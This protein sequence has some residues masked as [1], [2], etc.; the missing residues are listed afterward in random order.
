MSNKIKPEY[1]HIYPAHDSLDDAWE[2]IN[3]Q[4]PITETNDLKS[5]IMSYHN[6]LIRELQEE[7]K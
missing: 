4:L 1:V 6:T 5:L 3:S 2:F 7:Q